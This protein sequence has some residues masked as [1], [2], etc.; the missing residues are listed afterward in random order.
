MG[1]LQDICAERNIVAKT[2]TGPLDLQR[3]VLHDLSNLDI[4]QYI[5]IDLAA[6][7]NTDDEIIKSIVAIQ[8]MYNTRIIILARGYT[9]GHPL[10]SRIF[11]EG[12]YNICTAERLNDLLSELCFCID[13][14]GRQYKDAVIFRVDQPQTLQSGRVLVEKQPMRQTISIA[15]CGSMHRVGTTV[16]AIQIVQEI[17]IA[18]YTACY[19]QSHEGN[20]DSI[21]NFYEAEEKGPYYQCSDIDIYPKCDLPFIITRQYDYLIYDYGIFPE[22]DL[23]RFLSHDVHI[24]CS[25]GKPWELPTLQ[26]IITALQGVNAHYILSFVASSEQP[27]IRRLMGPLSNRIYFAEYGPDMMDVANANLHKQILR[28]WLLHSN[29]DIPKKK[30]GKWRFHK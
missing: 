2:M 6:I 29:D 8:S 30:K 18:G 22:M 24:V 7:S 15:I 10:L 1:L 28:P 27:V 25:G 13:G 4:Y 26:P 20:I 12:I 3:I 9:R 19:I 5:V 23:Q 14:S 16:H 17:M 11:A 21:L